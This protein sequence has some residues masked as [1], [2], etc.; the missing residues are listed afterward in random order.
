MIDKPTWQVAKSV[1]L[2]MLATMF[3]DGV[4]QD[5]C[6]SFFAIRKVVRK[7]RLF[8]GKKLKIARI[9]A[10]LPEFFHQ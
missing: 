6:V 2:Y 3:L 9:L 1:L 10:F 8:Y 7:G 4:C 5:K